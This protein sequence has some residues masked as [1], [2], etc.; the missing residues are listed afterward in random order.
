M[1]YDK[2]HISIFL[3]VF[4]SS[5]QNIQFPKNQTRYTYVW[6]PCGLRL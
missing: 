4:N 3:S 2:F 6:W 5:I 1:A